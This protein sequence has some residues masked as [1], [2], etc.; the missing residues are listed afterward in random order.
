MALHTCI[1][2]YKTCWSRVY[3]NSVILAAF[4]QAITDGV[5]I[6]SLPIGGAICPYF[7]DL[8]TIRSFIAMQEGI[9]VSMSVGNPRPIPQSGGN[10]SPWILTAGASM[11]DHNFPTIV[12]L[13]NNASC[14]R[15]LFTMKKDLDVVNCL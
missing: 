8:I 1:G 13:K 9:L 6:I 12:I 11:I 14:T 15:A 5:N 2:A 7:F 10:I 3:V 4:E